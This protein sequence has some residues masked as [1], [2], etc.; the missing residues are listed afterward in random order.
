MLNAILTADI[1]AVFLV[2][3]RIGSAFM[4]LP[5]I[6]EAF[7]STRGRLLLAVM[8]T[9]L[10]APLIAPRLPAMPVLLG[11]LIFMVIIEIFYGLFIGIAAKIL[12]NALSIAG[13]FIA[14]FTGLASAM[15][16]NPSLG[17]QGSLYSIFLSLLGII[18]FFAT[19][20]HHLLIQSVVESY[21]FFLPSQLPPLG[22]FSH[23]ITRLVADSF[24]IGLHLSA[25]FILVTMLLYMVLG[26]MARLMP[27]L[28]IF[29]VALPIQVLMGYFILAI[30]IG[31]MMI[32]F[33]DR[34]REYIG[35]W[36]TPL[37]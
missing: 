5:T 14:M 19:N 17:D 33:L 23:T 8:V 28:Q 2:F 20:M 15:M 26:V 4:V 30:S 24:K 35:Q 18:L 9:L 16:F 29:F 32:W 21:V 11:D 6:G 25:P 31:G 36:L 13:G 7:Y 3:A 37:A 34:Y 27:Q 10:V 12:F 1:F 22:D